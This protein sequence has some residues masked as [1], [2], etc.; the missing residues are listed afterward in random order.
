ML[1]GF[2]RGF[3]L[4][5]TGKR[6]AREA[7]CLKSA[8]ENPDI[9]KQ[10]LDKELKLGR[11][12]GPF[13]Q[14]PLPNLQCSP[15]GLVPKKQFRLI[16]HLSYPEGASINDFIDEKLCKVKYAS[17][18]DACD[19]IAKLNVT[20]EVFMAKLDIINQHFVCSRL[21]HLIFTV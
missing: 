12:A 10:K 3:R 11:I 17:F 13:S 1:N 14:R 18:D 6:S 8:I 5:F 15:L 21:T 4:G 19:M 7:P 16:H 9:V 20:G 2:T